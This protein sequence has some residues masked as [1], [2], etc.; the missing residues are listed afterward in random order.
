MLFTELQDWQ[1]W[2]RFMK[3]GR[4]R[5]PFY[6]SITLFRMRPVV[7]AELVQ[8]LRDKHRCT[9]C[10]YKMSEEGEGF[11]RKSRISVFEDWG[12]PRNRNVRCTTCGSETDAG[13][14]CEP[15]KEI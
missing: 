8:H 9:L 5:R 11:F 6:S 13:I 1:R 4:T 12:D 3:S 15:S 7:D 2:F 10:A 14:P